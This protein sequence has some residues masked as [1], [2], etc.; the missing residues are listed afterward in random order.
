MDFWLGKAC[1][2]GSSLAHEISV[3]LC[4][5]KQ[6]SSMVKVIWRSR[7][8][9]GFHHMNNDRRQNHTRPQDVE[10]SRQR[11]LKT[12]GVTS[13]CRGRSWE[14]HVTKLRVTC[15]HFMSCSLS[16]FDSKTAVFNIVDITGQ[17]DP[18]WFVWS[19]VRGGPRAHNR[20]RP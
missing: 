9:E 7:R 13:P 4:C 17:Q 16:S 5:I 20:K 18:G 8:I 11:P 3:I 1:K 19:A 2:S 6:R 14:H 12:W 10:K 15:R